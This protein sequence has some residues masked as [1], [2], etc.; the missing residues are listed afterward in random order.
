MGKPCRVPCR[1]CIVEDGD[2]EAS[3]YPEANNETGPGEDSEGLVL[4]EKLEIEDE[5]SGLEPEEGKRCESRVHVRWDY[6]SVV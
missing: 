2:S 5:K 3:I 1:C 4:S 6:E